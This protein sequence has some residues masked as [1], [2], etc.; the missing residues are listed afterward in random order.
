MIMSPNLRCLS[1]AFVAVLVSVSWGVSGGPPSDLRYSLVDAAYNDDRRAV[2][3]LLAQRGEV[4]AVSDDGF[5]ALAWAAMRSNVEIVSLLLG[6]GADVNLVNQFGVGPLS[7][8]IENGSLPIVRLLLEKGANRNLARESGETTLMTAVRL[9]RIEVVKLLLDHGAE[10][11][12]RDKKFGQ[13]AL[14]WAAGHPQIVRLLLNHEADLHAV[15]TKWDVKL[16]IYGPPFRTLGATGV[17]WTFQGDYTSKRG[18]QNTLHFAVLARDF[19][20]TQLLVGA[21]MDV[22]GG[23]A[24][25][26]PPLL[27]ALYKWWHTEDGRSTEFVPDIRTANFLLDRGAKVDV[28]DGAGYTPLHAAVITAAGAGGAGGRSERDR[29]SGLRVTGPGR[30]GGPLLQASTADKAEAMALVKRLLDAGADP[31]AQANYPT[32]GPIGALRI[33]PAPPGSSPF[34]FAAASHNIELIRLLAD[35]GGNPNLMRRDGHTPFTIAVDANDLEATKEMV[36]RGADLKLLYNPADMIPDRKE[37][38]ALPRREQTIMH[39]AAL[40]FAVDVIPYL[41]EL[42]VPLAEKNALGETPLILAD[43]QE[44][45]EVALALEGAVRTDGRVI[46]RDSRT[47]DLLKKLYAKE[48]LPIETRPMEGYSPPVN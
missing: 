19:E 33:N 31:N 18:G 42:G 26:T 25:G 21:G 39:L 13:T 17:P 46:P 32:P 16:P 24:D 36:A 3:T 12:G 47:T 8:A 28:A 6:A 10:V 4:N 2:A 22:N 29:G 7:L 20:S 45:V 30:A 37:A 14:M 43:N 38:K 1:A 15:S 27:L 34:H 9:G 40:A 5:T 23:S 44:V 48:G 11:N 35:H 41:C